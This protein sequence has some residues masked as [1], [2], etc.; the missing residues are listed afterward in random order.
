MIALNGRQSTQGG[1]SP[2]SGDVVQGQKSGVQDRVQ[3]KVK[4]GAEAGA[5]D[6]QH[7]VSQPGEPAEQ[8]A[9]TVADRVANNLQ[10][11]D[12]DGQAGAGKQQ[13]PRIAAKLK[14][15]VTSFAKKAGAPPAATSKSADTS[16]GV[17]PSENP[18]ETLKTEHYQTFSKRF[19]ALQSNLHMPPDEAAA[20]RIWLQVVTALQSN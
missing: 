17:L 15:G 16:R 7:A 10:G 18:A 8:E 3:R 1:G 6:A 4:D 5:E 19:L 13:A 2:L 9:E 11:G 14:N 12:N 20:Q